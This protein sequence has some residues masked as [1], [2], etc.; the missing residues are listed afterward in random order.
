MRDV[1]WIPSG[2]PRNS[3]ISRPSNCRV[4]FLVA[5]SAE[6]PTPLLPRPNHPQRAYF[7]SLTAI[8]R[9]LPSVATK[10]ETHIFWGGNLRGQPARCAAEAEPCPPPCKF[11]AT[12]IG[13]GVW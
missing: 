4:D 11:A 5:K 1:A 9:R 13:G 7:P 8:C 3:L 12:F 10:N 6:I 2:A